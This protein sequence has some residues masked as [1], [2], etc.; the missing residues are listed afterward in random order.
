MAETEDSLY[1]STVANELEESK[2]VTLQQEQIV[3]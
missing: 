2:N 3:V 1:Q